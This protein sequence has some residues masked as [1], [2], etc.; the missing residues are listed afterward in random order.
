M[1]RRRRINYNGTDDNTAKVF[2]VVTYIVTIY[3][4]VQSKHELSP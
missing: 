3:I 1:V 4:I 2:L